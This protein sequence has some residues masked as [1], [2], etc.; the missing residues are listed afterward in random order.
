MLGNMGQTGRLAGKTAL[1]TAAGQ[2]IGRATALAMAAEGANVFATDINAEALATLDGQDGI[3][4]FRL[5]VLDRRSVID[6]VAKAAPDILFNCAGIVHNGTIFDA[7]EDEW[8]F[9]H[10]L[11]VRSMYWTSH[12]AIPV[13]VERGSGSIVNISSVASSV[14]GVPNRFIYGVTKAAIIGLTKSIA[15]DFIQSGIRCNA[16]CPGTVESPSLNERLRATGD[17]EAAKKNFLARQPMGRFGTPEE[18]AALGVYLASDDAAF[19]TG[20]AINIDG[21]WT[22]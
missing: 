20:Q 14:I 21:G 2:G 7:T 6:G 17:F 11:N 15:N 4:S 10:N 9:G 16:I 12:A 19:V 8:D 22:S 13:M 3:T 1:V 5:D 18:I